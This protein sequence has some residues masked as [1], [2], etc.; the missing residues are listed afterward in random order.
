MTSPVCPLLIKAKGWRVEEAVPCKN[1]QEWMRKS[2][3]IGSSL[4]QEHLR[5]LSPKFF[6]PC[7]ASMRT[8]LAG[9]YRVTS[10]L[11]ILASQYLEV[12]VF[13]CLSA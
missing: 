1:A 9:A 6:G 3:G 13:L 8:R 7:F 11:R 10:R 2:A 4:C 12:I 5:L